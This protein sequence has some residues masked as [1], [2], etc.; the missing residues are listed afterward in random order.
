MSTGGG[1]VCGW[2]FGSSPSGGAGAEDYDDGLERS[3]S[4]DI[5]GDG[6]QQHAGEGTWQCHCSCAPGPVAAADGAATSHQQ[7]CA[8]LIASRAG[9]AAVHMHCY[10]ICTHLLHLLVL[11]T[12]EHTAC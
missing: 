2:D 11:C 4:S 1:N 8:S 5:G 7:A 10:T 3:G 9:Y 6:L 12:V